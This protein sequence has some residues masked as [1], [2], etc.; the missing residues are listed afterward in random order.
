[1]SPRARLGAVQVLLCGALIVTL[2]MAIQNLAW[3]AFGI[4][5]GM[6]ADR[7]GAFRVLVAGA[8]LYALGRVGMAL[9]TSAVVFALTPGVL[10]GAAQAGTTYPRATCPPAAVAGV[11]APRR[12]AWG[13]ALGVCGLVFTWYQQPD[14]LFTLADRLWSCF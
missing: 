5:A 8:A 12:L 6:L 4:F 9:A 2:A 13:V 10:I 14:F 11:A 1:M 7:F 3:G